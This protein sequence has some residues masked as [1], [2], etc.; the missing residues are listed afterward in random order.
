MLVLLACE[1]ASYQIRKTAGAHA[2]GM[3]GIFSPQPQVSDSDMHHGT[4]VTH[5]P[6]CMPGSL[7]SGFLWS[8][9][10]GKTFPAFPAHAQPAILRIWLE[11]HGM[12]GLDTS[13]S[14]IWRG[15][16]SLYLSPP[17]DVMMKGPF[18]YYWPSQNTVIYSFDV[19]ADVRR[20]KL[21]AN[22]RVAGVGNP[23]VQWPLLLTWFNFNPSMDK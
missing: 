23:A 17:D 4:C 5:V 10:R 16:N 2:L 19:F 7:T 11:A 3:P 12:M 13:L 9:W 18:P 20:S 15:V 14:T 1:W 8:R 21:L 6:W 22:I